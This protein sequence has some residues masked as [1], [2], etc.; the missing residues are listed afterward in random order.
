MEIFFNYFL[1][2]VFILLAINVCYVFVFSLA[3][4][5]TK[6]RKELLPESDRKYAVLVPGYKEDSVIIEVANQLAQID[7]PT[8]KFDVIIIADSFEENTLIKLRQ[9]PVKL[10]EVSF[11]KSTK[12]KS[13]NEAFRRLDDTYDIAV[14]MDADNIVEPLFLK[15]LDTQF[16]QTDVQVVQCH[17]VA[18]NTNT[19]F[20]VL[21]SVSEEINN[22][23]F[24]KGHINLG[25]ASS[26]IGSG[27]AFDYNLLKNYMS[28]INAVGGFD[29][30]LELKLLKDKHFIHY[31]HDCKVFDEKVQ[32]AKHLTNQRR[33]WLAAQFH[34]LRAY[35]FDAFKDLL[36]KGNINYFDKAFQMSLIPR[37]LLIALVPLFCLS[38]F[39]IPQVGPAIDYWFGI[40]LGLIIAIA[41]AIPR[42]LYNRKTLFA[43]LKLPY[44]ICLMVISLLKLKG[45]NKTFIHTPHSS[46]SN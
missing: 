20:A 43:I 34:Y 42:K 31:L 27:M 30:E 1:W 14:V 29:K 19:S 17:R 9:L 6:K 40:T 25:V 44:G 45:A 5:F 41:A 2:G 32:E 21:D 11:D 3:G 37:V 33:R 28:N 13:L 10:L 4:L 39:F 12:S 38:S 18:K 35:Y 16:Q 7:Y 22:Q 15:K 8:S 46:N 24:R 36:L 23:I 26:L